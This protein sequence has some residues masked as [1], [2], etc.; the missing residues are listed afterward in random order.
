MKFTSNEQLTTELK[1]L[2]IRENTSGTKIAK[3]I[4]ITQQTFS[5]RLQKKNLSFEDIR[6]ILDIL[7]YDLE[8]NFVKRD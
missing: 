6:T 8:I 7:G 3:K 4:G 2:F 5:Q 1:V